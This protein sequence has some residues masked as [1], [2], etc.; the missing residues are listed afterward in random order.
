M[1]RLGCI[2]ALPQRPDQC[3]PLGVAQMAEI[4]KFGHVI[5]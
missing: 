5:N 3:V 4:G 1:W 2:Q